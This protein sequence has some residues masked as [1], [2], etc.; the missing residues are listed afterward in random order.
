MLP[1]CRPLPMLLLVLL[2]GTGGV[3]LASPQQSEPRQYVPPQAR[4]HGQ[5]D[6]GRSRGRPPAGVA[7]LPP[8]PAPARQERRRD[9]G[10]EALSDSI[11]RIERRTRGQVLSAERVPY[12]GRSINRI[13]VMDDRGRVRIYVDDPQGPAMAETPTRGDDD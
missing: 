3:A 9:R 2:A 12:D 6:H 10:D 7:Q 11:R 13:K 8:L 4:A 1:R 5:Q